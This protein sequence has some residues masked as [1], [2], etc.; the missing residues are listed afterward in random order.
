VLRRSLIPAALIALLALLLAA[1]ASAQLRY[2]GD[3]GLATVGKVPCKGKPA[4]VLKTP[5]W[6]KAKVGQKTYWAKVK[7]PKRIAPGKKATVRVKLG[8]GAVAALAGRTTTVNVKTTLRREGKGK[9]RWLKV[10]LRRAAL[11]GLPGGPGGPPPTSA[12]LGNEPPLL[13]RPATAVDVSAVNVTWY[14]RDSWLDYLVSTTFSNGASGV[15]GTESPCPVDPEN[16]PKERP[17]TVNFQPRASWFDQASGVAG[18]YGQGSVHFRYPEHGIDLT[19]SDP[20]VEING[21]SSRLILRMAGGGN[22]TVSNQRVIFGALDP[23]GQPTKVEGSTY[24]YGMM[25]TTLA[26]DSAGAFSTF[27]SP[28]TPWGCV[29][30]S[31]TAP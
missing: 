27:Y 10:R 22:S 14:P 21:A 11:A 18:I 29:S 5:K 25:R 1:P 12:P 3:K 30:V 7:A 20:E 2:L 16:P 28:G 6:V 4:C 17:Y 8:G 15:I 31:F 23:A 19:A 9:K 24:T 26:A 13:A